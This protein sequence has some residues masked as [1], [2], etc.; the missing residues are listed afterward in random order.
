M[1]NDLFSVIILHYNQP[2][3]IL[4]AIDSVLCQDYKNIELIITDDAS[5]EIDVEKIEKYVEKNKKENIQSV[6]YVLNSENLG[7][8][9]TINKA[10]KN[11][12]GKHILFFAADDLLFDEK[13]VSN[14]AK[15]FEK[16]DDNVYMISSQCHMMDINMKKKLQ[17][18]VNKDEG[19]EFNEMSAEE[20]YKL[21]CIRCFLAMGSTAMKAEMFDRFGYFN[22]AYK[23]VED[24]S[25]FL[26]LTRNGGLIRYFDFDGLLHRDGGI[27]HT[28]YNQKAPKHVLGYKYDIA[29]IFEIEILPYIKKFEPDFIIHMINRYNQE[30]DSYIRCGGEQ[31]TFSAKEMFMLFP[32]YYIQK[33]LSPVTS[34]WNWLLKTA[35]A[36]AWIAFVYLILI[37]ASLATPIGSVFQI[38]SYVFSLALLVSILLIFGLILIKT[39]LKMLQCIKKLIKKSGV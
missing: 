37:I 19:L 21:L 14:F 30:K 28:V 2:K 23:Y 3:Y 6:S 35:K 12:H 24:W 29:R 4:K 20:Q 31:K 10:V 15:T 17:L 22:E 36:T 9:K 8:V 25:Y 34:N 32:S 38:L 39:G 18:F 5:T 27:S 7:T 33:K 1:K 16:C 13:V 11:C 26:H